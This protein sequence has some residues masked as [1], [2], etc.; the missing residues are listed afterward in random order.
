MTKG[1]WK[2]IKE[3]A[4]RYKK[5]LEKRRISAQLYRRMLQNDPIKYDAYLKKREE[6]RRKK[7][8]Q[9]KRVINIPY[10]EG[11]TKGQRNFRIH[12]FGRLAR[13]ANKRSKDGQKITAFNLWKIAKK[14]KLICP[15]TGDKLINENISIDHKIPLSAGGQN[16]FENIQLVT[17]EANRAK[18]V[19]N[20]LDFYL[21]C[22]KVVNHLSASNEAIQLVQQSLI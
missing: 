19:M 11:E 7:G 3:D 15:L 21:L 5:H 13:A 22:K 4:V 10:L 20:D 2:N 8:Y 12:P 9:K 1:E 6:W 17:W 16:I 18:N 14:Q